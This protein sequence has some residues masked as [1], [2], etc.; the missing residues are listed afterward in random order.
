MTVQRDPI[1][2]DDLVRRRAAGESVKALA[3]RYRVRGNVVSNL[4]RECGDAKLTA[5]RRAWDDAR[6]GDLIAAYSSGRGLPYLVKTFGFSQDILRRVLVTNGVRLRTRQESA[7]VKIVSAETSAHMAAASAAARRGK[8]IPRARHVF[9]DGEHAV[10]NAYVGGVSELALARQHG[11]ARTVIRRVITEAGVVPRNG[12]E[13]QFQ[14]YHGTTAEDR[15]AVTAAANA[16]MRGRTLTWEKRLRDA[17][18]RQRSA[19]FV[20]ELEN[21]I[22]SELRERGLVVVQQTAIGPYN[23]D[24]TVATGSVAVEVFGGG[25]HWSGH[26]AVRHRQRS[27]Y[28]LD[29]GWHLL[30]FIVDRKRPLTA[31]GYDYLV[32]FA[33]FA[34]R[35]PS[36]RREYRVVGGTGQDLPGLRPDLNPLTDIRPDE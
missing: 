24:L 33:E 26:H 34:E 25:W 29:Q 27:R 10:V 18:G 28:I 31:A 16:A 8:P 20:S 3:R 19:A 15:K 2:L 22:A 13:S 4:L 30:C 1:D 7:G 36:A 11:V 5:E 35:N 23:C 9:P 32:A 6:T 21:V 14:R 17:A 12:S